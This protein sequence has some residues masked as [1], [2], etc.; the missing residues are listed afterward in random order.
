MIRWDNHQIADRC[1]FHI[2]RLHNT[3]PFNGVTRYLTR[4]FNGLCS[5]SMTIK[6][7]DKAM[8]LK[9]TV[10]INVFPEMCGFDHFQAWRHHVQ[11]TSQHVW[12]G[13]P[14]IGYYP[15][16]LESPSLIYLDIFRPNSWHFRRISQDFP[17]CSSLLSGHPVGWISLMTRNRNDHLRIK[18]NQ[19]RTAI[20]W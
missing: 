1:P 7:G 13:Y 3:S 2:N 11:E 8:F 18:I 16:V 20:H 9:S 19:N 4:A 14:T 17:R 6:D 12:Q 10:L 5:S 15:A